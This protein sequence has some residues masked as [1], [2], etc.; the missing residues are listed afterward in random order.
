MKRKFES[1]QLSHAYL[2]TGEKGLGKMEFAR[3]F[4][5]LANCLAQGQKPCQKCVNCKMIDRN[6]FPD[7]MVL[8]PD[9]SGEIKIAK[10]REAQNFL[11]YKS[12]YGLFKSVIAEP[13][14]TMNTEAQSCFLKTLEEPKGKTLLLLVSARPDSLL[15][16]IY[17]RCQN[18]KFFGRPQENPQ[19]RE[20]EN[21]ILDGLL[22]T[23]DAD[24]AEKFKYVKS[25]DFE[26]CRLVNILEVLEKYLR[27]MMLLKTGMQARGVK[28]NWPAEA[29]R[30]FTP[31]R[32]QR[33]IKMVEDANS[34]AT[35]TNTS[36]RLALEIL[37]MEI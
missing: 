5:K 26:E 11:S 34:Q 27:E 33:A 15:A 20:A 3:E 36:P 12:Y 10:I 37:L 29:V 18:V 16:T 23:L 4:V 8:A 22:K 7:L 6:A 1:G 24:L 25:L 17:S 28:A 21:K 9:E 19:S 13:A 35:F 31:E 14:E 2:F 30:N 32:L